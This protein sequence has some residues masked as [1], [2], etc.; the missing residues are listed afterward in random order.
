M[1]LSLAL[2][3]HSSRKSKGLSAEARGTRP[4]LVPSSRLG[5]AQL[6]PAMVMGWGTAPPGL[7]QPPRCANSQAGN[8]AQHP[9]LGQHP[10]P[11]Q[12]PMSPEPLPGPLASPPNPSPP[13][14]RSG[15]GGQCSRQVWVSLFILFLF[16]LFITY[17]FHYLFA[18]TGRAVPALARRR[19][20]SCSRAAVPRTQPR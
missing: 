16:I 8:W 6:G 3:V 2:R 17:A 19:W 18:K 15:G 12:P 9:A 1:V 11:Q 10:N 7:V 5:Q 13:H 14:L 20:Q 4:S